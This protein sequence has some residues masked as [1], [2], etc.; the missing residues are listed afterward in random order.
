MI[1]QIH[2]TISS[3]TPI[4]SLAGLQIFFDLKGH[5]EANNFYFSLQDAT[6]SL[7]G[8]K[9]NLKNGFFKNAQYEASIKDA[10]NNNNDYSRKIQRETSGIYNNQFFTIDE[11]ASPIE[12]LPEQHLLMQGLPEK[13]AQEIKNNNAIF[14]TIMLRRPFSAEVMERLQM[15]IN[16]FPVINRRLEKIFHKTEQ[17]INIIPL[18]VNGTFLD[19]HSIEGL[20]GLKYRLQA[21]NY[22][23]PVEEGQ[24][25]IRA[26]RVS[27]NS[28]NDIRNALK[29]LLEAIRDESAYFSR[30]SN[31]FISSRLNEISKILTRLEDQVQMSKDEKPTFRYALLKAKNPG[32]TVQVSYWNTFPSEAS[33]VKANASF[34]AVQHSIVEAGSCFSITPA[35]GGM[36]ILNDYAQKQMLVR[37]LSSKGKIISVEDVKLLCYELFGQ[38]IKNV[39]V[40]KKSM[41]ILKGSCSGIARFIDIQITVFK[42]SYTEDARAH[43]EKQLS[44]QL[45]TSASFMFPFEINVAEERS[46]A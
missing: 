15:A 21:A 18:Q 6:L 27:K 34:K 10:F 31:D 35:L 20:N 8:I 22:D 25:I 5:S 14:C 40:K 38:K 17:W 12:G 24:A 43:L 16:A 13:L 11:N 2:F 33:F 30:T 1:Q 39:E 42:D 37:Q 46:G 29:S 44:Y 7:N 9:T 36:E 4:K 28:S 3:K 32:E 41:H 19:I 45:E 26:A 23:S